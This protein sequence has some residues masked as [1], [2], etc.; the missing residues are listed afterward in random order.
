MMHGT[1]NLCNLQ[2]LAKKIEFSLLAFPRG[3]FGE[4]DFDRA[5]SPHPHPLCVEMDFMQT[6]LRTQAA[7][8]SPL[9]YL[10]LIFGTHQFE[11]SCLM[12]W[13]FLPAVACKIANVVSH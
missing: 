2:S 8:D 6:F 13:N 7:I 3:L 9:I 10:H 5:L 12:N 4:G 11:I 1:E